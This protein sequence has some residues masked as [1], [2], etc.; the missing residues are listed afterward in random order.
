VKGVLVLLEGGER[1][2]IGDKLRSSPVVF[3]QG[4]LGL[5]LFSYQAELLSC[6]SRRD[7]G[8]SGSFCQVFVVQF[9]CL[10]HEHASL[11]LAHQQSIGTGTALD[12][13]G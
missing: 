12:I 4:V 10:S 2:G 9:A 1:V 5:A 3:A 6:G 13:F 11:R 7:F 8:L